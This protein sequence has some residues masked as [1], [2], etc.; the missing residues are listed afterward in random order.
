MQFES[1]TLSVKDATGKEEEKKLHIGFN[2]LDEEVMKIIGN[3]IKLKI[4]SM[5]TKMKQKE[6]ENEV[7]HT[8][9]IA[10][11]MSNQRSYADLIYSCK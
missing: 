9:K 3:V 6:L 4:D 7:I 2:Q 1:K 10:G 5:M 11:L 8:L